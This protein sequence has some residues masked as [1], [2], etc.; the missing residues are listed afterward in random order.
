MSK[1]GYF[2]TPPRASRVSRVKTFET[3][4]NVDVDDKENNP[5]GINTPVLNNIRKKG[6]VK[7]CQKTD[8]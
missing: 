5:S 8:H 2:K 3:P 7:I 1:R 4:S 6:T